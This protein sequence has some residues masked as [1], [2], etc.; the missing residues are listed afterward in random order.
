VRTTD[1]GRR[2]VLE[3]LSFLL[4]PAADRAR[5]VLVESERFWRRDSSPAGSSAEV[6]LWGQAPFPGA[7]LPVTVFGVL[8]RELAV[9]R[10]TKFPP[11]DLRVRHVFRLPPPLLCAGPIRR[12]LRTALRGGVLVEMSSAAEL[13]RVLDVAVQAAGSVE[14]VARLRLGSGGAALIPSRLPDGVPV[15]IRVGHLRGSA[16]IERAADAL[17]YLGSTNTEMVPRLLS[18][19]QTSGASWSVESRLGGRRPKRLGRDV[20][21]EVAR[22]CESLPVT[23]GPPEAPGH[24]FDLIVRSFPRLGESLNAMAKMVEGGL[25]QA[26]A[27]MRHGDLWAG[28]LLIRDGRLSGVVDWDAWHSSGVPGA[29]LLYLTVT[30]E[31]L[32][33][34]KRLGDVWLRRPWRSRAFAE[35]AGSYWGRL[36]LEPAPELLNAVGLSAWASQVASNLVRSPQLAFSTRWARNNVS[37]VVDGLGY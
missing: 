10:L 34:R 35:I 28:N 29:D 11:G 12:R 25:N 33:S 5:G 37:M 27:V 14:P 32:R 18:R 4:M 1:A 36:N 24:D 13:P 3:S 20:V 7:S 16:E 8:R 30:E 19:G 9:L 2:A 21:D 17:E 26:P 15:L 31:W 23:D 22:F 6:V